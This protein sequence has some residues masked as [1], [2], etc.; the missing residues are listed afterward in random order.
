MT[1]FMK[2]PLRGITCPKARS[3]WDDVRVRRRALADPGESQVLVVPSCFMRCCFLFRKWL[4]LRAS[5]DRV[6]GWGVML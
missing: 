3:E 6:T 2:M 4:M 5:G 1:D